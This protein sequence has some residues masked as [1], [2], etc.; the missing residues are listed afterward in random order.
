MVAVPQDYLICI[1]EINES[2][3][4]VGHIHVFT[5]AGYQSHT[6]HSVMHCACA[7]VLGRS[8]RFTSYVTF[9]M[10]FI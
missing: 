8:A 4:K 10:F 3:I 9:S 2:I 6:Q 5:Y 1:E 7:R